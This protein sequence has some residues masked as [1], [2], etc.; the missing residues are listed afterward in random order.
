MAMAP[1]F[2]SAG[3]LVVAALA[4]L[5]AI[6]RNGKQ[7]SSAEAASDAAVL[8]K[9]ENIQNGVTEIKADM[10]GVRTEVSELRERVAQVEASTKQ[11][12][13]R[14]DDMT[15]RMNAQ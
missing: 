11:A 4:L 15:A 5:A 10:K 8:V 2:I 6:F 7:D 13:H 1:T 12:H 14:I 9:L 3:S